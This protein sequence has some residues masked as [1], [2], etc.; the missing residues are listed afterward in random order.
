MTDEK[1]WVMAYCPH[2]RE[3][4]DCYQTADLNSEDCTFEYGAAVCCTCE[5][6]TE[7][8]PG[9]VGAMCIIFSGI[10]LAVPVLLFS[11]AI[12]L[13]IMAG[14][15]GVAASYWIVVRTTYW[16]VGM[17]KWVLGAQRI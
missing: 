13:G 14:A 3:E 15:F 6:C 9:D 2:C 1:R 17:F 4:T 12:G 10:L 5:K 16:L 11:L 8:W 7:Y